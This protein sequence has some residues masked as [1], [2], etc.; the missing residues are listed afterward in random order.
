MDKTRTNNAGNVRRPGP[1]TCAFLVTALIL[2]LMAVTATADGE[3]T[4]LQTDLSHELG[5]LGDLASSSWTSQDG[6]GGG[7]I[8]AQEIGGGG[9]PEVGVVEEAED[10]EDEG[11]P[12]NMGTKVKAGVL[13][14]VVPGA[15]QFYNGD[16]KKAYI[17]FGVEVAIWG[18]YFIFD[19][20]GDN[21]MEA[22][23]D[24]AGVYAGTGGD[25]VDRYWQDV[26]AYMDSDAF[27]EDRLREARALQEAPSGL[28]GGDDAWQWVND[29]RRKDYQKIRADGNSA[30]DRR[31]F[32]ILFAVV[33]RAISVVDAVLGAGQADGKLE[34]EVLGL[35]IGVEPRMSWQD[36][37]AQ[38]VISRS[39]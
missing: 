7:W 5:L 18:A 16:K 15:G 28:I 24:Y 11:G 32:M 4:L 33:N 27:N 2:S 6:I 3:G 1:G 25:H 12:S 13:S 36:P 22:S 21:R 37:G 14:A 30:Y 29:S 26:G 9:Q 17:M 31:D 35:N 39:F 8:G 10:E 34:T 19:H 20:Q 23:R 38:C